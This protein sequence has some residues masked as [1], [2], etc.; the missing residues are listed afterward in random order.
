[1]PVARSRETYRAGFGC[2][3]ERGRQENRAPG[4]P[5]V[6]NLRLPKEYPRRYAP[7]TT[8]RIAGSIREPRK[9]L[10]DMAR[11]G[12]NVFPHN[13]PTRTSGRRRQINH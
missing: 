8:C 9:V 5:R 3:A 6:V 1:M 11:H 12:V 13:P 2:V 7:G 10:D 4:E